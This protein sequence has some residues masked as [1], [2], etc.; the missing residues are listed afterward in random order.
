MWK[1]QNNEYIDI[2]NGVGYCDRKNPPSAV[3]ASLQEAGCMMGKPKSNQG[4]KLCREVG[5]K[6]FAEGKW[7]AAIDLYNRAICTATNVSSE[8]VGLAYANRSACFFEL[9]MYENC[10]VDINL[11]KEAKFPQRLMAK[12]DNRRDKCLAFIKAGSHPIPFEPKLSFESHPKYTEMA[13]V[14]EIK[15]NSEFG[16]HI[17][18]TCDIDVGKVVVMETAFMTAYR[19]EKFRRCDTCMMKDTNLMPCTKCFDTMFHSSECMA[20]DF[21]KVECG[22]HTLHVEDEDDIQRHVIRS[23]LQGVNLFATAKELQKFVE[24]A[25]FSDHMEIPESILDEKSKYR[26]FLKLWHEP[27]VYQRKMFGQQVYFVYKKLLDNP[28]VGSKFNSKETQ[29]FLM[30]LV[31]QH[32]CIINYSGNIVFDNSDERVGWNLEEF[33]SVIAMYLNH[34]CAPNATLVSYNGYNVIVTIRPIK[35]GEQ[36][37][38]SYFR[39]D[40]IQ[41]S[42]IDRKKYISVRCGFSCNCE[43]CNG[44]SLS[45]GERNEIKKDDCYRFIEQNKPEIDFLTERPIQTP[46]AKELEE[47]CIDLLNR[48][49]RKIWCQEIDFVTDCYRRL[50]AVKFNNKIHF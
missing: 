18:V 29:R 4:S 38:L 13:N 31:A 20:S 17:T 28:I 48:Y 1:K 8:F 49:G 19:F 22:M 45:T 6:Q 2:C 36:V 5:N 25:V 35:A 30:H 24:D 34:S 27:N 7:I 37:F 26:A 12:L 16:R 46:L 42:T 23:I 44:K 47:K 11:A 39:N 15:R 32:Y 14:L 33:R 10:L 9:Q 40:R 21:H 43:R 50:L 41:H 3:F